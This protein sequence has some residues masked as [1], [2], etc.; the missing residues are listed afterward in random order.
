MTNTEEFEQ[1]G[2][3]GP[4]CAGG[5]SKE[6]EE[7]E[8]KVEVNLDVTMDEAKGNTSRFCVF[9]KVPKSDCKK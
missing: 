9:K 1:K 2:S 3:H 4:S 5:R 7:E 6:E 8:V